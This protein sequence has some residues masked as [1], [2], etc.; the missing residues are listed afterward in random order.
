[1]RASSSATRSIALACLALLSGPAGAAQLAASVTDQDG[2]PLADAVVVAVPL[3]GVALHP[4]SAGREIVDQINQE[5]VPR[6]KPVFVGTPVFFPNKDNIRHQVYSFSP[7]KQ[8]ELP[9]YAGTPAKPVVFDRPGVVVLGCNIHDWMIAYVYVT[10]SPYFA[11]TGPDGRALLRDVPERAYAVRV[12]HPQM[13]GAE[14]V[15]R[16]DLTGQARAELAWDLKLKPEFR[17]HRLDPGRGI[18]RY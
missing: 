16:V 11:K 10:E 15:T 3:Q 9:L 4:P 17:P 2:N 1:M 6:V 7:A 12:W 13:E 8:F 5:F 14:P 18:G